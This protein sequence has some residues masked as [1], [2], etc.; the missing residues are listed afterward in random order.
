MSKINVIQG[1]KRMRELLA[2]PDGWV[3]GMY[4]K[5]A[6]G[7]QVHFV[8][9]ASIP[10]ATCFCIMG[11]ACAV[12]IEQTGNE[13]DVIMA[14]EVHNLVFPMRL[15]LE[16]PLPNWNDYPGRTQ[17]EVLYLIDRGIKKQ[18]EIEAGTAGV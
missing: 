15:L 10:E 13:G 17:E 3:Q 9:K 6:D 18:Q 14:S 12:V 5:R 11:A 2:K 7:S 16:Q 1:L 4:G 8:N